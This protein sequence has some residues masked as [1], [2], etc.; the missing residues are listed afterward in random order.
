MEKSDPGVQLAG[1]R[2]G[3]AAVE[4]AWRFLKWFNVE[5]PFDPEFH[6]WVYSQ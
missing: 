3:E 2:N 1:T 6:F 5:S 4:T